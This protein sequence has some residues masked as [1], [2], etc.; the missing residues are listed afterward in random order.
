MKPNPE[1]TAEA[2]YQALRVIKTGLD[3][4][5]LDSLLVSEIKKDPF[6]RLVR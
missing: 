6:R 3:M 5:N 4:G 2:A 1:L